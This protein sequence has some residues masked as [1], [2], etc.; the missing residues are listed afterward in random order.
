MSNNGLTQRKGRNSSAFITAQS[1]T[2][3]AAPPVITL[4]DIDAKKKKKMVHP[5]TW[6]LLGLFILGGLIYVDEMTHD[7]L[8]VKSS[9]STK[10]A[11]HTVS[12]PMEHS[13]QRAK[14]E[15]LYPAYF[16][17][18]LKYSD[19]IRYHLIFSTDCSAFQHWQSYLLFHSAYKV[20]QPGTITRI[21]SGCSEEDGE[22]AM[23]WHKEH[24]TNVF[25]E[26]FILFLTPHF[27]GVK[28]KDGKT[29][30][31]Y[32]FFNKPFGL[33]HWLENGI[34][35]QSDGK[36]MKNED[37]IVIL[38]DPDMIMLR[39]ITGDFSNDRDVVIGSRH[40]K[41]RKFKV[42]HGSPFAQKYGLG[43]QWRTFN[44]KE[45]TQDEHSP[46][47]LVS[48]QDGGTFYPVGAPYIAT[49]R[50]M[51]QI[52]LKWSDFVPRVH[53]EYP[54][55]LA[56][57]Y[58][59]CIAAAHLKL[60]HM[61]IDSM[62]ISN[63]GAGGEGWPMVDSM[64]TEDLC[65]FAK[66]PDHSKQSVPSVI[67]F[68]QRYALG[69]WFFSKRKMTTNF[70]ECD[71][72]LM[73]EPPDNLVEKTDFAIPF[74]GNRKELSPV[75]AKREGFT[76]C[77]IIAALNEASLFYKKHHCD[78]GNTEKTLNLNEMNARKYHP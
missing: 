32:K 5:W 41:D 59:F 18:S 7:S 34:G 63:T 12:V 20:N 3:A 35:F 23:K 31:D 40:K 28:D 9:S 1:A 74:G 33:K 25:G 16:D 13:K 26:R 10:E 46:A 76:V 58:A 15:S 54:Y 42:E 22:E 43:A 37:D 27:S 61:L 57:M 51:Y 44:L 60:P 75:M 48:Q 49:V 66:H 38:I 45:I 36:T 53:A 6:I 19:G 21:A 2:A 8:H 14:M 56:E 72:P 39:P 67:H 78:N 73:E 77:A 68:C 47:M 17:D 4:R 55:L 52:A 62:M 50:D 71:S 70:F 29:I 30:G 64:E 65:K 11:G 69:T 24:V